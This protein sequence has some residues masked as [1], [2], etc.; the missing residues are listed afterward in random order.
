MLLLAEQGTIEFLQVQGLHALLPHLYLNG[1]RPEPGAAT[2]LFGLAAALFYLLLALAVSLRMGR[3]EERLGWTRGARIAWRA[4]VFVG[5]FALLELS[6]HAWTAGNPHEMYVPDPKAFWAA[7]PQYLQEEAAAFNKV[8]SGRTLA[9]LDGI[10][11]QEHPPERQPGT[12]RLM[13]L[14]HSQLLSIGR[15]R[16]AGYA[17]YPKVLQQSGDRG[18]A[19]EVLECINAGISGYSSWQGLLLL[20]QLAPRYRPDVAVLSFSYH[21]ANIAFSTDEE[22]MTDNPR[23]H[24]LRSLLY[25]S[26][27]YLL[28]RRLLMK[29]R[30]AWNDAEQEQARTL[31]VTPEQYERNLRAMARLAREGGFRVAILS[32]PTHTRPIGKN[33][34][35]NREIAR[36]VSQEEGA[37]FLDVRDVFD[38]MTQEQRDGYFDDDIHM[39]EAG[40]R[41]VARQV[42]AALEKAGLLT[43]AP[44]GDQA[45]PLL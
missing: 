35:R 17:T 9:T 4:L 31:R 16:Y 39:S 1:H 15:L 30:A 25:T 13:F 3:R 19:G 42:Q 5:Y 45:R 10:M 43:P 20:R 32:E 38:R 24:A 27:V 29:G 7:N 36:R 40:H 14:G 11:D 18:P 34:E 2:V 6:L 28:V 41:E 44:R 21:D 26:K 22:V 8:H 23:V 37:L 12:W 33:S